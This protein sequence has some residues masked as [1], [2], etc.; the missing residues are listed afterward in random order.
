LGDLL[1]LHTRSNIEL[2]IAPSIW[3]W[4]AAIIRS[5]VEFSGSRLRNCTVPEPAG[6]R[7]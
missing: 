7:P 6:L 2:R 4:W 5:T 1:A 3:P